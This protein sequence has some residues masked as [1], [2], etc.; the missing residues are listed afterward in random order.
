MGELAKQVSELQLELAHVKEEN[1]RL[2][3]ANGG[4]ELSAKP[5]WASAASSNAKV[6][7]EPL[8]GPN[9]NDSEVPQI[10]RWQNARQQG[11]LGVL[12]GVFSC[13]GPAVG[14]SW[15]KV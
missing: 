3:A 8:T 6:G 4:N 9:G 13:G 5:S 12:G 11:C 7:R 1:Q 14:S 15:T 10:R 2:I